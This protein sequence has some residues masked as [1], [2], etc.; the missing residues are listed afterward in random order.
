MNRKFKVKALRIAL[1]LLLHVVYVNTFAKNQIRTKT[2][3]DKALIAAALHGDVQGIKKA[4]AAGANVNE[5]DEEG[6]TPL[7]KAAKLSYFLLVKYF[8]E[9]VA[10]VNIPNNESITPLHYG[11]E[12]NNVKIERLLLAS[13]AN[14]NAR[15]GIQECPLHWAGWTGNIVAAKLPLKH[16]ATPYAKNDTG[17]TPIGLTV[18]QEHKKL[19]KVFKKKRYKNK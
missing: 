10:D 9:L 18:R 2:E 12:Y 4:I 15:D 6:F 1:L 8:S 17:V 16:G 14:I 13:D 19:E 11:V 3:A 5:Q 7:N